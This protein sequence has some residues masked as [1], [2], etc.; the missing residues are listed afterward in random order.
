MPTEGPQPKNCSRYEH[1]EDREFVWYEEIVLE[2]SWIPFQH[3]FIR[4]AC[5][6]KPLLDLLAEFKAEII[7]EEEMDIE[8]EVRKTQIAN[9][10]CL[11][12]VP[13]PFTL[14]AFLTST[15]IKLH[16]YSI[17][18]PSSPK[19]TT[20]IKYYLLGQIDRKVFYEDVTCIL[21][22]NQWDRGDWGLKKGVKRGW[23]EQK[24][25]WWLKW[26]GWAGVEIKWEQNKATEY[27]KRGLG[28][29]A[30]KEGVER[31]EEEDR[32]KSGWRG[33]EGE[34][35]GVWWSPACSKSRTQFLLLYPTPTNI[36]IIKFGVSNQ[37][38]HHLISLKSVPV[39]SS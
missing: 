6:R 39:N 37:M 21:T 13:D 11:T 26:G 20:H 16:R 9:S 5:D 12:H 30:R 34:P 38:G 3:P 15:N 35:C 32:G 19:L 7:N 33:K 18:T 36:I 17:L 23:D 22:Q 31:K 8:E 25:G 27:V 29:K 28:R 2:H 10:H 24:R 14:G 4:D 1:Q